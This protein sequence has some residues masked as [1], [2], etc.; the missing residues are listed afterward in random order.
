[1]QFVRNRP[2]AIIYLAVFFAFLFL[3]LESLL[4]ELENTAYLGVTVSASP[5]ELLNIL[6]SSDSGNYLRGAMDLQ[7][8]NIQPDNRWIFFLWPPGQMVF[9]A[10]VIKLGLSPVF[11]LL[12]ILALLWAFIGAS[13]II[14][15][16]NFK[17]RYVVIP[18]IIW[19]WFT[20]SPFLGW[21]Q[22]EGA[23][24]TDGIGAA[25]LCLF[26]IYLDA[27]WKKINEI[28]DNNPWIL[29]IGTAIF[30]STLSHIRL[31][32]LFAFIF[33]FSVFIFKFIIQHLITVYDEN[34]K[35]RLALRQ[36]FS[37]PFSKN[38]YFLIVFVS[39]MFLAVPF[40]LFKFSTTGTFS[41]SNSDYVWAQPWMTTEYLTENSAG[42][43]VDG[44]ANWA[45]DID[46]S[47]CNQIN[48]LELATDN[49][50]SGYGEFTYSEFRKLALL[51]IVENP[52]SFAKNRFL[53]TYK[54]YTSSA[55]SAVG[56][57]D[58]VIKG[59]LFLVLY[60]YLIIKSIIRWRSVHELE[61]FGTSM[62]IGLLLP[63]FV[64]HFE[65]RYL[66]PIQSL[67]LVIFVCQLGYNSKAS[68]NYLFKT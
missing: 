5:E 27:I 33:S 57:N 19:A 63:L 65:T 42:F 66:I 21:N 59:V 10:L 18:V 34:N 45:C 11:S 6:G 32:F 30:M 55:G 60:L 58:N 39:F 4:P 56:L 40:S 68:R 26:F 31:V 54:T 3:T 20:G 13:I 46:N 2:K 64:S 62:L 16:L 29:G 36:K 1:M 44:G 52:L 49:P 61:L 51:S 41:W 8:L 50:F 17:Y 43:L 12:F 14:K 23:L 22:S 28:R 7:D 35:K 67:T 15:V 24:G 53:N 25:L 38:R 37:Y 9:L 48:E 47:K